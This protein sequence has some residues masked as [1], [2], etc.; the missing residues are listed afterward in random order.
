MQ[1]YVTT[2]DVFLPQGYDDGEVNGHEAVLTSSQPLPSGIPVSIL[3]AFYQCL[4]VLVCR[5]LHAQHSYTPLVRPPPT[6][7]PS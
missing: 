6:R 2:R 5:L 4:C 3:P 1:Y 7:N